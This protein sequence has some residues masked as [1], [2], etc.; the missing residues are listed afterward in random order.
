MVEEAMNGNPEL[1]VMMKSVIPMGRIAFP[2]EIADVVV[3]MTSSR[4]SYV[5]GVGWIVDGG[6]TL[7]VQTY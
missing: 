1:S 4:S 2:E 6:M 3:F 5:T 7:Q